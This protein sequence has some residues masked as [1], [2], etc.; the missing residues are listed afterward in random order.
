MK[1]KVDKLD[2]MFDIETLGISERAPVVEIGVILFERKTGKIQ[3]EDLFKINLL[4]YKNYNGS[5]EMDYSTVLFWLNQTKIAQDKVFKDNSNGNNVFTAF[6]AVNEMLAYAGT[7][8]CHPSFDY[9]ILEYHLKIMGL[10][11]NVPFYKARDLRTVIDL[12]GYD[13]KNHPFDGTKHSAL[14]DCKF[15]LSYLMA[16][17]KILKGK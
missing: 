8:W 2:A 1:N 7:L 13:Y 6:N 4:S 15:Q 10:E 17:L 3:D 14:D 16:C 12:S 5:F 11:N 9:K